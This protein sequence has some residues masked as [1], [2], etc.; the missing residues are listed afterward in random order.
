MGVIKKRYGNRKPFVALCDTVT[1]DSFI[2]GHRLSKQTRYITK[3]VTD[4]S[5]P[6]RYCTMEDEDTAVAGALNRLGSNASQPLQC[7]L[8]LRAASA[9]DQPPPS[10]SIEKFLKIG[11][12]ANNAALTNLLIV[13]STVINNLFLQKPCSYD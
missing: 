5:T 10:Q 4:T 9:F 6:G 12:C 8:N 1:S 3:T 7:Y 2:V 13:G 11:F